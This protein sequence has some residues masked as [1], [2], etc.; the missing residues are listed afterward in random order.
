M[1]RKLSGLSQT[2]LSELNYRPDERTLSLLS[3][4]PRGTVT[5]EA[6]CQG[7][8]DSTID[9]VL[10]SENLTRNLVKCRTLTNDYGSDH[11]AMQTELDVAPLKPGQKPRLL[12]ENAP[13]KEIRDEIAGRLETLPT[14]GTVQQQ[15]DYLMEAVLGTVHKLVPKAKSSLY[16][17]RWW[18]KDLTQLRR[19]YIYWRNRARAEQALKRYYDAIWQQKKKHWDEFLADNTNIWKAAKYL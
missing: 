6:K 12:F 18:T 4:L 2:R 1:G 15:T 7:Q 13:W 3:A 19:V 17:K 11:L 10:I 14:T 8:Q 5:W 9:L 16:A